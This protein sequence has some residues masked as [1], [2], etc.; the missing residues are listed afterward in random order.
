MHPLLARELAGRDV[1][2]WDDLTAFDVTILHPGRTLI[3]KLLRVN[4]FVSD[5]ARRDTDGLPRIGRQFYDIWALLGNDEVR[6]LLNDKA[7][8]DE[9][10]SSAYEVSQAF[11]P[12]CPM[13]AG[14]FA[15]SLAFDPGVHSRTNCDE[16]MTRQCAIFTTG[17]TSRCRSTRCSAGCTPAQTYSTRNGNET[18]P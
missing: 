5:P 1:G 3:E 9:I 11:K 15:A 8:V 10:I 17:R 6:E 4:N 14:G 7:Q 2:Q 12:D 18:Q 13:P 16:N